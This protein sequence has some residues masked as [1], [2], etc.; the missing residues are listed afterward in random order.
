MGWGG[1][2]DKGRGGTG[3][4]LWAGGGSQGGASTPADHALHLVIPGA[5]GPLE[6][7]R[8]Q[9][10]G[11]ITQQIHHDLRLVP[12]CRTHKAF[13][14]LGDARSFS[15][16][17]SKLSPLGSMLKFDADV[18]KRPCVSQCESITTSERALQNST[19][20]RPA[21]THNPRRLSYPGG[22]HPCHDPLRM[23]LH[24]DVK[25]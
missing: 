9:I 7:T 11:V 25:A 23:N 18:N 3:V 4:G 16:L 12:H 13:S 17:T 21:L 8:G 6:Q 2:R 15:G 14:T 20:P 5:S 1:G 22:P 19:S 10:T 24:M